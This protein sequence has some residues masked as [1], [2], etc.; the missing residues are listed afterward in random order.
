MLSNQKLF[1]VNHFA[2]AAKRAGLSLPELSAMFDNE[3]LLRS[4]V[5]QALACAH[6][7]VVEAARA[8]ATAFAW[9][10]AQPAATSTGSTRTAS[11]RSAASRSAAVDL[12]MTATERS[13]AQAELLK[14]VGPIA[15]FIVDQIGDT[16][17]MSL[18][19]FLSQA[20]DLADLSADKRQEL[21]AAC[22]VDV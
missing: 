18:R 9:R 10:D 6:A 7:P 14:V 3:A 11:S 15:D 22:D 16:E 13:V 4:H 17:R 12:P 20:A 19:K 5:E 8:V 2:L 21:F 1:L